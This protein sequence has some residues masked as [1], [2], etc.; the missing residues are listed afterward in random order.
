MTDAMHMLMQSSE[1]QDWSE[2]DMNITRGDLL[3]STLVVGAI[4]LAQAA[5][6]ILSWYLWVD[7]YG[8]ANQQWTRNAWWTL[9]VGNIV[10][11]GLP[12]LVWPFSYVGGGISSFYGWVQKAAATLGP[13]MILTVMT[14][15]LVAGIYVPS[16]KTVWE[17]LVVYF[18]VQAFFMELDDAFGESAMMYYLWGDWNRWHEDAKAWCAQDENGDCITCEGDDENCRDGLEIATA[19]W[20]V[21]LWRA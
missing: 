16:D 7:K 5:V 4:A 10:V 14:L 6:P 9:W 15:L 8:H 13:A 12:G 18:V 11:W 21:G 19:L 3:P 1:D 20:S 17:T 2:K